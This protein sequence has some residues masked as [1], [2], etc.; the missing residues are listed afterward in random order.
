MNYLKAQNLQQFTSLEHGFGTADAPWP[1]GIIL[2]SQRHTNTVF[3]VGDQPLGPVPVADA[4]L[5]SVRH[6]ILGIKTADCLPILLYNP[7]SNVAGVIHA[8]WRGLANAVILNTMET[9]RSV[10]AAAPELTYCSIG[11][12][13]CKNCYEVGREVAERINEVTP[14]GDAFRQTSG[15]KGMLDTRTIAQRQLSAAGVPLSSI[16]H[17]PL[18]TRCS[19]GF[20]SHR[21]GSQER[22]VSYI[23]L[24]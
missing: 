22:Q 15:D 19:P 24:R 6:R 4:L 7:V 21:A 16:F 20:H 11:P 17:I 10:Y 8:G 3:I 18:C 2:V 5:T 13:I 9:L 1:D 23:A 12:G 14:V